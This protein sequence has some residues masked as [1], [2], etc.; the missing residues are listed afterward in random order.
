MCQLLFLSSIF[1]CTLS[2]VAEDLMWVSAQLPH[3]FKPDIMGPNVVAGKQGPRRNGDQRPPPSLLQPRKGLPAQAPGGA[4]MAGVHPPTKMNA[5][6]GVFS[7]H[8]GCRLART[9]LRSLMSGSRPRRTSS[10]LLAFSRS[11][12]L[13]LTGRSLVSVRSTAHC[14]SALMRPSRL[15]V[16]TMEIGMTHGTLTSHVFQAGAPPSFPTCTTTA[17]P[18][19]SS[20]IVRSTGLPAL[21][22]DLPNRRPTDK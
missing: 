9:L 14:G 15:T 12:T 17:S 6:V 4:V 18:H 13:I 7:L 5:T 21:K 1:C 10:F 11:P 19:P 16:K 22:S 20:W 3:P 8:R 2:A